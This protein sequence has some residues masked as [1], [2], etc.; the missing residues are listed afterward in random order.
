M[1]LQSKV[2][3]ITALPRE[4]KTVIKTALRA[5]NCQATHEKITVCCCGIGNKNALKA[6]KKLVNRWNCN[7]LIS[8][9]SAASLENSLKPGTLL[10][11][12]CIVDEDGNEYTVP[13]KPLE[14]IKN[15]VNDKIGWVSMRHGQVNKML[16]NKDDKTG[17]HKLTHSV[18][19]DME[20]AAIAGFAKKSGVPFL[21]IRAVSDSPEIEIPEAVTNYTT[22]E[23]D[24]RFWKFA[25]SL[26]M[27]PMQIP[28][29]YRL[30]DGFGKAMSTLEKTAELLFPAF[31]NEM[32]NLPD[33]KKIKTEY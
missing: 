26:F 8:W 33:L 6:A 17:L 10:L 11:P 2:G 3:I 15:L 4:S 29:I 7:F 19:A 5:G 24:I 27:N 28:K 18:S 32:D 25:F 21:V 16:K 13:E 9:G 12:D 22:P 31:L 14:L 20:S 1:A 30:A 23:G